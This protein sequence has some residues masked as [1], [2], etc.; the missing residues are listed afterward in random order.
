MKVIKRLV[1]ILITI[2]LFVILS[3][4]IFNYISINVLNIELPDINGYSLLE[5]VSGSMEPKISKG[6]MIVI[7]TKIKKYKEKDIVTFKD[8]NGSFVTHRILEINDDEV[9]T[10]GDANNTIDDPIN[11]DDIVGKYIFQID[12]LGA[13]TKSIKTPFS[14]VMIFIIG[15]LLC[16]L[17]STDSKGNAILTEEEQQ[18]LDFLEYKKST[19]KKN[20]SDNKEEK[21]ELSNLKINDS[22]KKNDINKNNINKNKN[23][24]KKRK[25][26]K[27]QKRK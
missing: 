6:D 19:H 8:S 21:K 7:D 23:K 13:I 26:K 20:N 15:V 16:I 1:S 18:Y 11:L 22:I 27:K 10:K 4:N 24:K 9:I 12:G 14:L 17:V 3:F 5:V 2:L 25:K